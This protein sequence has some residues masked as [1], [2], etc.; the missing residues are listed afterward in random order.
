MFA[1]PR[2]LLALA[3]LGVLCA[4]H[5]P[6]WAQGDKPDLDAINKRKTQDLLDKA[7]DEYR[8]FFKKPETGIEYWSA[9]KFEMDLGKFD[10]AAYHLKLMLEKDGKDAKDI[11]TDLVKLEQAEGMSAFFRL[12]L[13][14]KTDWSDHPPFRDEASANVE[15]LI[16]RVTKAVETHL[17]DPE[18]IKKFIKNLDAPTEEERGYAYVQLARSRERAVPYLIEALRVDYGKTIFPKVRETMIRI[19]PE[20]VP[21][22]L[23][24]FKAVN[25]KDYRD[26]ELRLTL[27]DIIQKRDD[28]R[29]IPYLWHMVGSKRYPD[30]VRKKAKET[31]AS[32]LR[33][34]IDNVPPAKESLTLLA[35]RYY[36]HKAPFRDKEEVPLYAWDGDKII[37]PAFKMTPYQAEEILGIRYAKEA[38]DIDPSWQPAQV[39]FLSMMLERQYRPKMDQ[40][41][42]EPLPPKMHQLLTTIDADLVMRVLERALDDHQLP[43]A[44]PLIQALG[45][46]GEIRAARLNPGG[47]PRGVVKALYY[48]DRRVQFAAVRAMLKMPPTTSPAVASDRVVELSRRFL[49]S[50]LKTK[51]LVVHS[52]LGQEPAVRDVVKGLGFDPVARKTGEAVDKGKAN[53]DFD[54]VILHRGMT[55]AEFPIA[56]GHLRKNL[57]VGGLPMLVVVDKAREKA[58]TKFVAKDPGVLV[59]TEAQ[60]KAE[61][62]LKDALDKL[63]KNAFVAKLSPAERKEF[64]KASMDTLWRMARGEIKGYD[65]TP[66]LDTI[67]DQLN[68]KDYAVEAVEILGRLPGKQIQYKL[69]GIV[70]DPA[71]DKLRLPASMELNRHM[72]ANGVLL[73]PKLLGELKLAQQGAAEGTPLRVQLNVTASLIARTTAA[74]TGGELWRFQPDAPAAPKEKKEN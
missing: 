50:D 70:T 67:L 16:D 59:I 11:D 73:D 48:P 31:L 46:R 55:E 10:L 4:L 42:L 63:A 43:V 65:I 35:E 40:I 57:D 34:D 18:R 27:L 64:S 6:A 52:P 36:Q 13:V 66:A 9:I 17:S 23:E 14:K 15:K 60:F 38:L 25:D 51:A 12:R 69:A 37:M 41:L 54:L 61:D 53:A 20:T 44:L 32:L 33:I 74:K 21:V 49:A 8:I 22:Y 2:F 1:R 47:Q 58:V 30:A 56:Y 71:R 62:E 28:K 45:E 39:V 5:I 19:G 68:S 26:V 24:A 7:R 3:I 29:V 72:Q